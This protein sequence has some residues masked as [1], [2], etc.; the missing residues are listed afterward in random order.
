MLDGGFWHSLSGKK[1]TFREQVYLLVLLQQEELKICLPTKEKLKSGMEI[2]EY[3]SVA[4]DESPDID[5]TAQLAIFVRG[6]KKKFE[7]TKELV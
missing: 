2:F 3:F 1:A 7:V 6:T 5:D 4:L